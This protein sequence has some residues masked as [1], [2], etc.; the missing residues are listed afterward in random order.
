MQNRLKL[1]ALF[2]FT[3]LYSQQQFVFLSSYNWEKDSE[4]IY[5]YQLDNETGKLTKITSTKGVVNPSYITV[6]A[7]GNTFM[8]LLR[9]KLKMEERSVLF[10]LIKKKKL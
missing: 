5:V 10:V 1:L 3:N 7:D 2:I 4:G 8:H 9:A 6:S